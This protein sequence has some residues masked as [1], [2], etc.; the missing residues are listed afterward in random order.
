V[1]ICGFSLHE[2][3]LASLDAFSGLSRPT[4]GL[5]FLFVPHGFVYSAYSAVY[6]IF[7]CLRR[8]LSVLAPDG[9]SSNAPA[10]VLTVTPGAC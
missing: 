7:A 3:G 8:I 4:I 10:M 5:A 6:L 9:S 1:F 2:Y